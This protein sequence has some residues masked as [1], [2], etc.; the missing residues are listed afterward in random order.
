MAG[1][2]KYVIQYAESKC[3]KGATSAALKVKLDHG[4]IYFGAG[5]PL[6]NAND[7]T[8][9]ENIPSYGMCLKDPSKP[10]PCMP[11]TPRVWENVNK[12]HL[13]EGA[14]ALIKGSILSCQMGGTITIIEPQPGP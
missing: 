14:P 10:V 11:I 12:K 2:E 13:I 1:G 9:G 5:Y 4:V 7:H 6:M 8:Q 3:S